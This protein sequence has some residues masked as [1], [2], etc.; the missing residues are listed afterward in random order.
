MSKMK[1]DVTAV[2]KEAGATRSALEHRKEE[3]AQLIAKWCAESK[4]G[5]PAKSPSCLIAMISLLATAAGYDID[6]SEDVNWLII[7][8]AALTVVSDDLTEAMDEM[9][10][11]K[12]SVLHS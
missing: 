1:R 12:P 4:D 11:E 6:D 9:M 5:S 3:I 10:A 7:S 8:A 2:L